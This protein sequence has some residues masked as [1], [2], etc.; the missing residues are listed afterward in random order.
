VAAPLYF[1]R[2]IEIKTPW[3][4]PRPLNK[5]SMMSCTF[6]G[7]VKIACGYFRKKLLSMLCLKG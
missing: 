3:K 7:K 2:I 4:T 6:I 5:R 1:H